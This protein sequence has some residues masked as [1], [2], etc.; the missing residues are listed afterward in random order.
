MTD[1]QYRQFVAKVT[2]DSERAISEAIAAV[3]VLNVK[4]EGLFDDVRSALYVAAS[5]M[6][7]AINRVMDDGR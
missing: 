3:M 1:N 6:D 5:E 7:D 2:Y 4:S